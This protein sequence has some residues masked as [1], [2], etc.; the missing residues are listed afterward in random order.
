[1]P[2]N[3]RV[4]IFGDQGADEKHVLPVL[5]MA[6]N[7]G[8]EM[9]IHAG[10]FDYIDTPSIFFKFVDSMGEGFPY[11]TTIGNHDLIKWDGEDGYKAGLLERLPKIQ[12]AVCWGEIG[13]NMACSFKGLLFV[14]SGVG[15]KGQ[16]HVEFMNE[17]FTTH[18]SVWKI[19]NWHKNQR[20]YQVGGKSDEVGYEMYDQCGQHGA[21]LA[22]AHEHS[23]CRTKQMEGGFAYSEFDFRESLPDQIVLAQNK[24][25]CWVSGVGGLSV[26]G[27][28]ENLQNNPWW[29]AT[30]SSFTGL[31]YGALFCTFNKF[32]VLRNAECYF[33]DISGVVWDHFHIFSNNS[34][35]E[36][37]QSY[38]SP[39]YRT[40]DVQVQSPSDEVHWNFQGNE[41]L[42]LSHSSSQQNITN[43]FRFRGLDLSM[44]EHSVVKTHFQVYGAQD[45]Q[46]SADLFLSLCLPDNSSCTSEILWKHNDPDKG[47]KS[48]VWISRDISPLFTELYLLHQS[49]FSSTLDSVIVVVRGIGETREVVSILKDHCLGPSLFIET[50]RNSSHHS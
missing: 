37:T 17:V 24:S 23:Y 27:Y 4:V 29:A 9:I 30:A 36:T 16:A 34:A 6:K 8:A 35:N 15:T 22:T 5:D 12:D 28:Y 10:D 7:F 46:G 32:G 38:K 31:N 21:I 42:F 43:Y 41:H 11:F 45:I 48:E 39:N 13:V 47:E 25:V 2:P 49:S 18:P 26:R 50:R 33:E 44:E 20:L 3:L 14:L 1:M 19:C 40:I